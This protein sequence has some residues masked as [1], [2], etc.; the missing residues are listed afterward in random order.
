VAVGKVGGVK[1]AVATVVARAVEETGQAP[2]A[3]PRV[4]AEETLLR[5]ENNRIQ[6]GVAF[7]TPSLYPGMSDPIE[8]H[9]GIKKISAIS[10]SRWGR[11]QM[12]CKIV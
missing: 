1:A 8:T 3:T 10:A 11:S 4:A 12:S 7:S 2:P 5:E 6:E 9:Y